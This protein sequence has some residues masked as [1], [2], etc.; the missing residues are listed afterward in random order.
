MITGVSI[1]ECKE[2]LILQL[3]FVVGALGDNL[4]RL[5]GEG[6]NSSPF[7]SSSMTFGVI[8]GVPC[9]KILNFITIFYCTICS[10]R[11]LRIPGDGEKKTD[12]YDWELLTINTCENYRTSS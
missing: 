6:L 9:L 10:I 5:G 8:I 7:S 4:R 1:F 3:G 12:R 11:I 2:V